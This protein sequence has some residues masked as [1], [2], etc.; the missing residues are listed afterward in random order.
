MQP[1][2]TAVK[3]TPE[4]AEELRQWY[5]DGRQVQF[6]REMLGDNPWSM[7]EQIIDA[8]F[9]YPTVAVKSCNAV[10]KTFIAS[11]CV[12]AFLSLKPGSIVI[13]TAPTWR[14]VKDVLWREIRTCIKTSSFKLTDAQV[15]QVGLDVADDWFAVGLSTTNAEKFFGYHADDVLVVI[16]EASGVEEQIYV[17]VDAVTPNRN[18]HVLMIGNPTNPDGRFG[19]SFNGQQSK[20]VKKF[21]ISAFDSPNFVANNIRTVDQLLEV[22]SP[23]DDVDVLDHMMG[24]RDSLI[25]PNPNLIEPTTAYRRYLQWGPESPEWESLI[26]GEFPSQAERSLIPLNLIYKSIDVW[27]QMDYIDKLK[28]KDP[29]AWNEYKKHPEWSIDTTGELNYGLD[30]AR[31]GTDKT[32]LFAKRGGFV[33]PA[34]VWAKLDT[35]ITAQRVVDSLS[36]E[37]WNAVIKVDDTGVGGG[38]TDNLQHMAADNPNYH[39]RTI[40]VNFGAGTA[41]PLKFFNIRAE[42]FWN[43]RQQFIKHTIA[44]PDDDDLRQELAAIR[45]EM[46]GKD[47]QIIK[48]EAK[49]DTKKRLGRSPDRADALALAF[50]NM[51]GADPWSHPADGKDVAFVIPNIDERESISEGD[52]FEEEDFN[53]EDDEIHIRP[54]MSGLD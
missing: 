40:P 27:K 25:L 29:K 38:V 10:G 7:Q 28:T 42:M 15:N 43:L 52:D 46:V 1:S 21:T 31:Y 44:I 24:V 54:F 4:A 3:P 47:N 19:D 13:T 16:D 23:P 36:I 37:D 33:Q 22:F 26:M 39:Y 35:V 18:A 45:F 53:E 2:T 20:L 5:D 30:V 49:D 12:V 51:A 17:G 50:F 14:Q 34:Q 9:K 48:I 11:R 6:V 8:V 32:V 41:F